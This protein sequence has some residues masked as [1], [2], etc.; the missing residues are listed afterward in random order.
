MYSLDP[1][2]NPRAFNLIRGIVKEE[3]AHFAIACNLLNAL[4]GSPLINRPDFVPKYPSTL[5]G[6]VHTSVVARLAP[7][8][9]DHVRDVLMEIEE[10][11][12]PLEFRTFAFESVTQY[13][14][15]G[16]FYRAIRDRIVEAGNNAFTGDPSRQSDSALLGLPDVFAV[17]DVDSAVR[18]IDHIVEQGEGT[19][20]LPTDD[21]HRLAH[22]YRFAEIYYGRELIPNPNVPANAPPEDRFWYR[23]ASI[24]VDPTGVRTLRTDPT[25]ASYPDA[26]RQIADEFNN[27]YTNMLSQLHAA[28][29]G[30]VTKVPTAIALM[31]TT[32]R[33][34]AMQLVE[35]PV[36]DGVY[37][38]PTF[39]YASTST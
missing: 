31:K 15:I 21:H 17:S 8:S 14:T 37:A 34:L 4:G 28:F 3:M 10:P 20:E 25:V 12:K 13:P 9:R 29:T 36:G 11:E 2:A 1:T 32:L 19:T 35:I 16:D 5:P 23:G 7:F 18:A 22:Y 39:E 38:G 33:P 27:A 24:A 6:A 26:A 30:D